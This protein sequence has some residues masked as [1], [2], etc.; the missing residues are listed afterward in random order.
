[1]CDLGG[2]YFESGSDIAIER[3]RKEYKLPKKK[4]VHAF[5]TPG[6]VYDYG[7]GKIDRKEF[8]ERVTKYLNINSNVAREMEK[9]WI[10]LYKPK[11]DMV[12]LI[13]NLRRNYK[14]VVVS[15]NLKE[16]VEFLNKKTSLHKKF[17]GYFYSF[18]YGTNKP[19]ADLC[20]FALEKLKAKP[21]ECVMID[22]NLKFLGN[23]KEL[24]INVIH[25]KS[26]DQLKRSLKRS[27]VKL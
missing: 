2:V 9:T 25:F 15:G 14:V 20:K 23:V 6:L 10:S 3:F 26:T 8:W 18:D 4:L 13:K 17:D 7:A 27:G 24:G 19:S 11:K 16:R 1:M 12:N 21:E 22:D 5:K